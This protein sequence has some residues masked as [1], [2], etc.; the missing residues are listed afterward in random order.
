M[1]RVGSVVSCCWKGGGGCIED[2]GVGS[3]C[4]N[5]EFR[6]WSRSLPSYLSAQC[7]SR[8][9]SCLA[10]SFICPTIPKFFEKLL[11]ILDLG[12]SGRALA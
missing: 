4:V 2:E 6:N 10:P 11:P 5:Y 1:R 3:M 8:A 12:R 9:P 7:C